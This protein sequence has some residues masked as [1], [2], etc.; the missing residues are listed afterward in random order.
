M[1]IFAI[2]HSYFFKVLDRLLMFSYTGLFKT[3][4]KNVIFHPIN[5]TFSYKTISIGNNVGIGEHAYF[6]AAISHIYIGNN[7]AFAPNVTIR[8]GNHSS[9]LVGKLLID[10]SNSDKRKEDD[11]PVYIEDDCWIAS[12]VV[13]LKGVRIGRGSI[14]AAGAIVNNLSPLIQSLGAF[15]QKL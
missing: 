13:I 4:G 7:I 10:Y 1:K 14:I 15:L 6:T 11:E 2:L 8:G 9:H 3:I 12:N 5:S